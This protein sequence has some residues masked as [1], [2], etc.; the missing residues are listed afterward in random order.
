[1]GK[2]DPDKLV[3]TVVCYVDSTIAMPLIASS[4]ALARCKP[5]KPRRLYKRLPAMVD[6]LRNEYRKTELY[7]RHWGLGAKNAD[8]KTP[9]VA[10]LEKSPVGASLLRG[11]LNRDDLRRAG[12]LETPP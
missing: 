5:R 1:M 7:A 3:D 2:I 11:Q 10:R 9:D 8:A 4:P 6:A 12:R